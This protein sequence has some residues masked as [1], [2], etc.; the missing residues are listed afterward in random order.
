MERRLDTSFSSYGEPV[1]IT[2]EEFER[3]K[4]T[5]QLLGLDEK[6]DDE[7]LSDEG[8]KKILAELTTQFEMKIVLL[9]HGISATVGISKERLIAAV[10]AHTAVMNGKV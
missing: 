5:A 3:R 7:K 6:V 10:F 9:A 2:D 4:Y 1:N 8:W